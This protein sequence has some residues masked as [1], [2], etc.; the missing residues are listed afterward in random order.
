VK[1]HTNPYTQTT[2]PCSL[3]QV[4]KAVI[5]YNMQPLGTHQWQDHDF[6]TDVSQAAPDKCVAITSASD[7]PVKV[8][9]G[10]DSMRSFATQRNHQLAIFVFAIYGYIPAVGLACSPQGHPAQRI[11]QKL[12]HKN[13]CYRGG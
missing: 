2:P 7:M 10:L 1:A 12:L 3:P 6:H 8:R 9:R 11:R 5:M 4:L 13:T